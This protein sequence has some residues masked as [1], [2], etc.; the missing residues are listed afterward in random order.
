MA[1]KEKVYLATSEDLNAAVEKLDARIDDIELF[2]FPNAIIVGEPTI[3]NGQISNF[4][5]GSYLKFPFLVDFKNQAFEI[6]MEITTGSNVTSQ[7]NIFDSD[8]GLAFAIRNGRF[9][10]AVSSNGSN[11]D[12]GEGVGSHAVQANST[13]R[14]KLS[15]NKTN[16][17]LAY[18]TDGGETFVTDITM[19]GTAQPYPKQI[20][21]G[22]G[23]NF[24]TEVNH[25]SGMINMNHA[26]LYISDKLVWQGMDDVGL[27]T[28]LATDLDNIDPDGIAKVKEIVSEDLKAKQNK[29]V[30]GV[31]ITI[32]EATNTISASGGVSEVSWDDIENKPTSFP[33]SAHN[34][35]KS[36]ISDF[37]TNV[38]AFNNDA[39]YLTKTGSDFPNGI[40]FGD[41]NYKI[42]KDAS[43]NLRIIDNNGQS[44]SFDRDNYSIYIR[45]DSSDVAI[46]LNG[47]DLSTAHF[48]NGLKIT[49]NE[50]L[51][52][53][54]ED[55]LHMGASG[56]V[57]IGGQHLYFNHKEVAL[58]ENIPVIPTS[59]PPYF[60]NATL[61]NVG[62]DAAIGDQNVAGHMVV[63][64][65]NGDGGI[66]FQNPQG[67]NI[68]EAMQLISKVLN[69][70]SG[71]WG[72]SSGLNTTSYII[73]RVGNEKIG[74]CWGQ[75]T[76]YDGPYKKI[77]FPITFARSYIPSVI[78]WGTNYSGSDKKYVLGGGTNSSYFYIV[79]MGPDGDPYYTEYSDEF[80][81]IAIGKVD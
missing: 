18:S 39:G 78:A 22:I 61:Y 31:N 27:A 6:N 12:L 68:G 11:W 36:Q 42:Y 1:S 43:G 59:L 51:E 8:F 32:D 48:E 57:Y 56:N 3:N 40:T 23:E 13:Y 24:A 52:L 19:S 64:G 81:W 76:A 77:L 20:F 47:D 41:G 62:D 10:I 58:K 49:G 14:L 60:A 73:L 80:L 17:I 21:I 65:L 9:V 34:H 50:G 70:Q 72:S 26:N 2:K 15:W 16:Y 54:S 5:S 30:P 63:R 38:S 44:I 33:P 46:D 69:A 71:S 53:W 75:N 79:S 7:E 29:L 55:Q 35:T 66:I 28:R 74:I 37:P 25:F 4:G 67:V 45:C